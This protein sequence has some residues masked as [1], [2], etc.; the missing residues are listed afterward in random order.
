MEKEREGQLG[1]WRD[2]VVAQAA[3]SAADD[4]LDDFITDLDLT[5]IQVLRGDR[6]S[7]RYRRYLPMPKSQLIRMGLGTELGRVRSWPDSLA[8]E[9]EPELKA[10]G[11]RLPAIIAQGDQALEQRRKAAATRADHRVRNITSLGG[12][13]NNARMSLFGTLTQ[14][15]ATARLPR[16]WPDRFFQ[17][18][19]RGAQPELEPEIPPPAP[20]PTAQP[21]G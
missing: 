9:P 4:Q 11:E 16:N 17:H 15:A 5:F 13:I 3:V 1:V 10:L 20:A 6:Q 12:D 14:K 2:E 8:S 19:S 7:P 18:A 21:A